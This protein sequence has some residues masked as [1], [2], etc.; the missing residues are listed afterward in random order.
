MRR[1]L[2]IIGLVAVVLAGLAIAEALSGTRSAT[3]RPAHA[4]PTAVLHPPRVTL[5]DVRG[6]PV[7]VHFWASWCGPCT[8]EAAQLARLNAQLHGRAALIGV[9]WSDNTAD[10]AAFIRRH[11]WTFANLIDHN[12]TTGN[13]Y[14]ISGLPTTFVLDRNGRV[15]RRLTGPQTAR[16]LLAAIQSGTAR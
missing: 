11:G 10:A 14:G 7:I 15:V 2:P 9:D 5:A 12:G 3:G 4:L 1:R 13:A 8:K 6:R 16:G